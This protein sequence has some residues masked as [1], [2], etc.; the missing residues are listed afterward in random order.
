MLGYL[1]PVVEVVTGTQV[2][3]RL[4]TRRRTSSASRTAICEA[5]R[6]LLSVRRLDE[7]TVQEIV[8]EAHISRQTFYSY[9]DTKYAVVASLI[10]EMGQAIHQAWQ[11]FFNGDGPVRRDEL[12]QLGVLT[13]Q[14]WREQAALYSA[15]IEGWHSDQEIH[16]VWNDVLV[17]FA[18][19]LTA[20]LQRV[21]PLEP[22]DDM[23]VTAMIN[24]YERCSYLAVATPDS[25]LGRSDQALAAMLADVWIQSL[26]LG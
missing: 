5:V 13:L 26:R 12:Q 6:G 9:F 11:P 18:S 14:L 17:R 19:S 22:G 24:L 3:A 15:T 10:D 4:R 25:P 20:R 7:L 2:P 8:D 1:G 21:R 16:D 23:L